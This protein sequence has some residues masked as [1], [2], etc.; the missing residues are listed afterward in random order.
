M[1]KVFA[2]YAFACAILFV[3][4]TAIFM[5]IDVHHYLGGTSNSDGIE[6]INTQ[7]PDPPPFTFEEFVSENARELRPLRRRGMSPMGDSFSIPKLLKGYVYTVHRPATLY[8]DQDFENAQKETLPAGGLF[9]LTDIRYRFMDKEWIYAVD[10]KYGRT[11]ISVYMREIEV[12]ETDFYGERPPQD[13]MDK[14]EA[15]HAAIE[16]RKKEEEGRI[17][18]AYDDAVLAYRQ[19]EANRNPFSGLTRS[20]NAA[21][22]RISKIGSNGLAL[23]S[24]LAALITAFIAVF[25]GTGTWLKQSRAWESDFTIDDLEGNE[26]GSDYYEEDPETAEADQKTGYT[27]F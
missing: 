18:K 25:L 12:P 27:P 24:L 7:E 14:R 11:I 20:I 9:K 4:L 26:R 3:S 15:Q 19:A 16:E 13:V 6:S 8:D 5:L 2:F 22:S 21:V 1:K 17:R 23:S 10:V